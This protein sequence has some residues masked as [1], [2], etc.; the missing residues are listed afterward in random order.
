MGVPDEDRQGVFGGTMRPKVGQVKRG[1][2]RL[3]TK[4]SVALLRIKNGPVRGH[5]YAI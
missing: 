4:K 3:I 2:L 5:F 1:I